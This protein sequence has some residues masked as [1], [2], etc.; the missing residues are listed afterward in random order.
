MNFISE[1]NIDW[2]EHWQSHKDDQ[3]FRDP[4]A[5]DYFQDLLPKNFTVIELGCGMGKWYP[6]FENLGCSFYLGIDASEKA[7][8]IAS[9]K[10]YKNAMFLRSRAELLTYKNIMFLNHFDLAFTH[11][12]LQHTKNDTKRAII[13]IIQWFLKPSGLLVIQEKNDVDTETTLTKENWVKL[14]EQFGF[15]YIR[16]TA[17]GDPRNGMVFK[18]VV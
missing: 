10:E 5:F 7:I 6:I 8:E 11:T 4:K 9:S 18:R 3:D 2:D 17:E 12:F 14:I 1:D 16:S 15:K 13:R